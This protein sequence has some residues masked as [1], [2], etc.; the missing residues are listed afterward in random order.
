MSLYYPASDCGG[1]TVPA[2][3]CN[4]C[5]SYEYGRIRSVAFIKNSF[6][7]TDPT[8]TAQWTTG[9]NAGDIIIVWKTQGSY[10]GGVTSEQVGF[11]DSATVN[12]NTTHTL[13]FKD[14]N[15]ADNCDFY[16]AIKGSSDYTIAFRTSSQIHLA[17]APVTITPKNVIADDIN[18]V[19]VW[20]VQVKWTNPDSPCAYTTPASIF[21][22]CYIVQ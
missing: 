3:A 6:T 14:P 19:V 4:P 22:L 8:S 1:S 11:G 21:D 2:Y 5:P 7:F 10:D 20:E 9:V 17:G 15:Y 12:G 16:N 18:S 13:V